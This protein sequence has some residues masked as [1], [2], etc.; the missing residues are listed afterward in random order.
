MKKLVFF[1]V[2]LSGLNTNG[3]FVEKP[4]KKMV[5]QERA[6]ALKRLL[7]QPLA[8]TGNYDVKY[9]RLNLS[10]SLTSRQLTGDVTTYFEPLQDLSQMEFDFSD[11][12]TV[13]QVS[14]HN[15]NLTFSQTNNRLIIN[16]PQTISTGILDSVKISYQGLVPNTGLDSYSVTTHGSNIPVVWTLSEPYG[17]KDWWP[18]KQD[19]T[20]KAD[21]VEIIVNYPKMANGQEMY[22]VSNGLKTADLVF[23]NSNDPTEYKMTKWKHRYPIAAYLVAF[24]ITNY[25]KFSQNAGITQ[26]FPIDNYV[27][28]ENL[29]TAQ[30][31][32]VN[33]VPVMNYFEN[34]FGP[35]PFNLEK[36]GQIQFGWGGGMEHQTAT[37]VANYNRS[38]IAHELAHQWFGDAVTCGSWHDIWLN[39]GFATYSEALTREALDGTTA[40]DYW[41]IDANNTITGEPD[42]SVYVQ[43]TTDVWRIFS[44]R[45]SYQKGAMVLNMLRSNLGDTHFF[46]GIRNYFNH[47]KFQYAKTPDFKAEMVAESGQNLDEFFNDW[48]YGQGYPT[49][50]ITV[51]RIGA[52]QYDVLVHQTTSDA[53]VDFF[54]MKLPFKFTDNNGQVFET[55]LDNTTNDQHFTVQT[56][57]EIDNVF[58]DI[59]HDIVKGPTTLNTVLKIDLLNEN[60]FSVFPNPAKTYLSI[61]NTSAN[62]IESVDIIS[63]DG[64]KVLKI[65]TGFENIDTNHLPKGIYLLQ[66]RTTSGLSVKKLIKK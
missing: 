47:K 40:F 4:F 23:Y 64:K 27:Y 36:Y 34:T 15:Q 33:F 37:F 1:I 26:T 20:D 48:I 22:A 31:Q 11:Q 6:A 63:L 32:S 16:F 14:W 8:N 58:F 57:F 66:I 28:P 35:Y 3:Q 54:E 62:P 24:A 41:K 51:T 42:G 60:T 30:N 9:H 5:N 2:I 21:S 50:T 7:K 13:N 45:L 29:T 44:W 25:T 19:L 56:G 38:L 12:M 59:H 53:S 10:P 39:E 46:Q 61:E 49:Y 17:A 65:K 55:K 43:D 52:G 18:C